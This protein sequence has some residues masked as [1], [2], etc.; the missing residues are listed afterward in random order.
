MK[1]KLLMLACIVL[2]PLVAGATHFEDVQVAGDCDGWELATGVYWR[3][4]LSEGELSYAIRLVDAEGNILE[5]QMWTG[6]IYRSENPEVYSFN[7]QWEIEPAGDELSVQ[8]AVQIV[9]DTDLGNIDD[10]TEGN[11]ETFACNAVAAE[12]QSWSTV[13]ELYR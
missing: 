7:G 12:A 9:T 3:P 8:F 10:L 13:K 6:V 2:V 5:T 1:L 11:S 4:D